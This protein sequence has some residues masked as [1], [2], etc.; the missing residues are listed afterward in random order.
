MKYFF[1]GGAAFAVGWLAHCWL[2]RDARNAETA[3]PA[4]SPATG[5]G[6]NHQAPA[7]GS[8]SSPARDLRTGGCGC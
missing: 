4:T 5:D 8:P 2:T 1:I 6:I 3:S 7:T